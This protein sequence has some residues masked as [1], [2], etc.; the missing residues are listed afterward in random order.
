MSNCDKCGKELH[1]ND[2]YI[3]SGVKLCEECAISKESIKNPSKPC[4]AGAAE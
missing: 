3:V 4:G 2:T 1:G